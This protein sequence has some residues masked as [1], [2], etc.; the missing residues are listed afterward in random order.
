M[1]WSYC[2]LVLSHWCL[3]RASVV[4]YMLVS[5]ACSMTSCMTCTYTIYNA[6]PLWHSQFFPIF[7][8]KPLIAH[9]WRWDLGCFLWVQ[10]LIMH[11]DGLVQKCS[12]S[13]ELTMEKP[14]MF[15]HHHLVSSTY[16]KKPIVA[17]FQGIIAEFCIMNFICK[18]FSATSGFK[19]SPDK[20]FQI[21][22]SHISIN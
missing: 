8:N 4:N 12:T 19:L 6:M 18:I 9:P 22:K 16:D 21:Q 7:Y 11:I 13:N 14:W 10:I 5:Y 1:H 2:S 15:I 17:F 20:H 3:Y